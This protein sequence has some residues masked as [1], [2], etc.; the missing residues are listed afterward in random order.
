MTAETTGTIRTSDGTPAPEAPSPELY[1]EVTQFYAHQM[2]RMDGGDF[3]GF[4]GSFSPDSVFVPAGGGG[5]RG[6]DAIEAAARAAAGRFGDAQSRHWFD[7]M[8]VEVA[9]DGTVSTG[10]Y[11]TVT[12]AS[13]DGSVLVEP[14]CFVRDTLVR[15]AGTLRARSRVIERDDL[16]ARARAEG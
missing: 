5:L 9:D 2:H 6:P 8:T 10:Y 4:A 12:V 14:T 16:T 3:A 15:V 11:A 7:M 13:P 1:V